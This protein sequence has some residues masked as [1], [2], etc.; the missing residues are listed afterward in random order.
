[1]LMSSITNAQVIEAPI[2]HEKN[3]AEASSGIPEQVKVKT[4]EEI[5]D[6]HFKDTPILK[7]VASCESQNRQFDENGN[8]IRGFQNSQDVGYMQINEKYHLQTSIKLG[9]DIY[10][11]EGNLDYAKY[12]YK[13]QGLKPW[14]YSSYC[15][16]ASN[17]FALRY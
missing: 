15:W 5:V 16:D 17:Q 1:M 9:L 2:N 10:T 11:L 6:E 13:T 7:K 14:V 12:L 4:T 3:V 8:V